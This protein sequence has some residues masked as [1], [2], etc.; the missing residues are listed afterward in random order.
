MMPEPRPAAADDAEAIA[1]LAARVNPSPWSADAV[2]AT[3][4]R[5]GGFVVAPPGATLAGFVLFAQVADECEILD[6][7]VEPAARRHGLGAR[8]LAVAL[9]EAGTRGAKHCFLEVRASNTGAQA[10]YRAAGFVEDGRRKD[11]YRSGTGR[12]DALLM[13]R[14]LP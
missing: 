4:A 5:A 3:L 8:L 10:F 2:R 12:E 11:Y 7:A 13:N 14:E 9:T 6:F 1:A